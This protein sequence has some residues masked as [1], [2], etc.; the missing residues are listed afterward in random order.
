MSVETS[1][2]KNDSL[3]LSPSTTCP[4]PSALMSPVI[5]TGR[6][7]EVAETL[8]SSFSFALTNTLPLEYAAIEATSVPL[9]MP[10]PMEIRAP[11]D[12]TA[13]HIFESM[14]TSPLMS[15]SALPMFLRASIAPKSSPVSLTR[16]F[17]AC[18]GSSSFS[19]TSFA[20]PLPLM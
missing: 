16:I 7:S 8:P 14:S 6:F 1:P 9:I 15:T 12:S 11:C 13:R 10:P 5:C 2:L 20:C 17:T 4:P 18:A 3:L 19:M